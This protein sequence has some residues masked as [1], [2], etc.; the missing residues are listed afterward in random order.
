MNTV[1]NKE[2]ETTAS[3][4]IEMITNRMKQ[5]GFSSRARQMVEGCRM[6]ELVSRQAEIARPK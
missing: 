5:D 6:A 3:G 4:R 1:K 2:T